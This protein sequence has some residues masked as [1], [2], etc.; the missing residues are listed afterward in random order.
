MVPAGTL[1]AERGGTGR[2]KAD[3]LCVVKE[4]T[5]CVAKADKYAERSSTL[6]DT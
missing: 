4:D 2:V 3:I 5:I 6:S 1:Y